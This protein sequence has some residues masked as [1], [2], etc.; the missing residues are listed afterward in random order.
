M[1]PPRLGE[2]T[3]TGRGVGLTGSGRLCLIT[4]YLRLLSFGVLLVS[5]YSS[6]Q[7]LVYTRSLQLTLARPGPRLVRV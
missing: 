5:T 3:H 6:L 7:I 1:T 4:V 2:N